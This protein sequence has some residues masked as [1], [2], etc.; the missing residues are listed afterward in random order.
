MS[1]AL[2]C[3][4]ALGLAA[5]TAAPARATDRDTSDFWAAAAGGTGA[6]DD[7]TAAA[8]YAEAMSQGDALF[9][10]ARRV[11]VR[12]REQYLQI[13]Q[14]GRMPRRLAEERAQERALKEAGPT[15]LEA[16]ARYEKAAELLPDREEPHYR[17]AQLLS[18][19]FVSSI[20]HPDPDITQRA[21]AH[22][23]AFEALAPRDVRLRTILFD[24]SIAYTKLG[25]DESYRRAVADYDRHIALHDLAGAY[26]LNVAVWLSNSGEVL[27]AL[28]QLDQAVARYQQA[29]EYSSAALYKYGLAVALD[30]D[31]REAKAR[32]I[33]EE[34][35]RYDAGDDG[36]PMG[37]LRSRD[38]FFIPEGDIHYYYALGYE[39][40]GDTETALAQYRAFV[41][42]AQ[43]D[44]YVGQARAHIRRLEKQKPRGPKLEPP[45]DPGALGW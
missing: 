16:A 37:S 34:A 28:G 44:R 23:N 38:V 18:G 12:A 20:D 36:R 13:Y 7:A 25:G 17:A 14:Q 11:F 26:G 3:L 4:V 42:R 43:S 41:D 45:P 27:M 5:A 10:E 24:R 35:A 31:G 30:R 22:W 21:I 19:F 15:V 6:N 33:M 29:I 9:D 40:L 32:Q 8:A 39:S 2:A 1:R